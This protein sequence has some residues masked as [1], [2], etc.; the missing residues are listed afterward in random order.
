MR[1]AA[2]R[3]ARTAWKRFSSKVRAHSSGV[4][5]RSAP[6]A[7]PPTL[8]T[9]R[10]TPPSA[11]AAAST[12]RSTSPG[13]VTSATTPCAVPP[14][15]R[16]S[17]SAAS[18]PSAERAQMPTRQPS[19]A[20]RRALA[21]PMPRLPPV[22]RAILPARPRSTAPSA[23]GLLYQSGAIPAAAGR[24]PAGEW[25]RAALC[26]TARGHPW[27]TG[28]PAS[29]LVTQNRIAQIRVTPTVDRCA[30][31]GTDRC[32]STRTIMSAAAAFRRDRRRAR[33]SS[34]PSAV[35]ARRLGLGTAASDLHR[36][37]N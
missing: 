22:T 25:R 11:A 5:S 1:G 32:S 17:A 12:N 7:V 24:A 26:L 37:A 27:R 30:V 33:R 13:A 31:I 8:A 10:S 19:A 6:P 29:D 18:S 16:S 4:D 2:A 21:R 3:I 15:A 9:S 28:A 35:A 14:P 36:A 23:R 20:S 34:R